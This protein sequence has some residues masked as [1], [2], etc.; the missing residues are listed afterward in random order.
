MNVNDA[1]AYISMV[2]KCVQGKYKHMI[3]TTLKILWRKHFVV[4]DLR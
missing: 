4:R 1:E 2:F 3:T